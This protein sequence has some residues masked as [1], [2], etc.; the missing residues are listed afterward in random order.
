MNFLVLIAEGP[1]S[2]DIALLKIHAGN[3]SVNEGI[4]CNS[5][6]QSICL[7][8]MNIHSK[9]VGDWCTVSGWGT[10]MRKF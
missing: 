10:G 7:P 5:H 4:S 6:V 1:H 9:D 2:N 3:S 8:E